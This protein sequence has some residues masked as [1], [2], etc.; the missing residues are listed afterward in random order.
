[1]N[2]SW[3]EATGDPRSVL[4][5]PRLNESAG[6]NF[7]QSIFQ[8]WDHGCKSCATTGQIDEGEE[9]D[10][11]V[12][13]SFLTELC[14]NAATPS[15]IPGSTP[16]TGE[17]AE[18]LSI[19]CGLIT[20]CAQHVL[21][22]RAR[23]SCLELLQLLVP[24]SSQ[25]WNGRAETLLEQI[26]PYSHLLMTDPVAKVRARSVDV[27]TSAMAQVQE[28]PSSHA[29]LFTEYV[30]PQLMSM[31]S[32][33]NNEPVVLLSVARNLGALAQHAQRCAELSQASTQTQDAEVESL[34]VQ[35]RNLQEALKKIVKT[36]LE[37]LP[38]HSPEKINQEEHL[39]S[40]SVGREVK[41]ALLRNMCVLADS[42]GR[43]S[44]HSF[45][46][47]YLISFMNDPAWEVRAAFCSEAAL[48]PKRVGQV[49]SEGIVWPCYEQ[50]LLDQVSWIERV[51]EAALRALTK[52]VAQQVL[53]RQSLVTVA[54]KVA[55][56]LVHP[57][58]PLRRYASEVV[59]ALAAEL[60]EVDQYVFLLPA[61]RPYLLMESC[62]LQ[63]VPLDLKQPPVPRP[64]YQQVLQRR[65]EA[66]F[67]DDR[68]SLELLRPYLQPFLRKRGGTV[69]IGPLRKC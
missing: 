15:S 4:T 18:A 21:A 62:S 60:S 26:I 1:M 5:Q 40:L 3:Q 11:S 65:D 43:E 20:S 10:P 51:V 24:L 2:C 58:E 59:D 63:Q 33:M 7:T 36:L 44:T 61:V 69:L 28:L 57:S 12:Y 23:E 37:L 48:L 49:S 45:L 41:I 68:S 19:I 53:R 46:L 25:E 29:A 9:Q 54:N 35:T 8:L 27:L 50:A 34:D 47:P 30:L 38:V 13:V 6:M 16:C 56:L 17:D 31:M 42:F 66:I 39:M 64:L 32:G 55:P 14:Q 67:E 22:P 52:L